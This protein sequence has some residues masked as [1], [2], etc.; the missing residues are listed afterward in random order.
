MA[1][2]APRVVTGKVRFSYP[3]VFVP[4]D[5]GD[6]KTPKYSVS[7]IIP[8]SDKETIAKINKAF[9]EAKANSAS[10]FG[11]T[12]PK[13]L[14]GG[15]RDGDLEKEDDAYAGSMFINANT[16]KKPGVVDADMNAIIDADEFYS[17]CY[18]RAAIEFFPYNIE[19][20]KGIA[21]GLGNVQKLEDGER[22]GGGGVSAAVDFAV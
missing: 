22:L 1:T 5:K 18:G 14:K 2:K 16:A 17:G 6:G 20:S 12:V 21:C 10:Y 19:G 9:E 11:G 13:L 8:K 3:N 4:V 15:L 7:I